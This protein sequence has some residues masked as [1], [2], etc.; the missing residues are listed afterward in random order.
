MT[1]SQLVTMKRSGWRRSSSVIDEI[2]EPMRTNS[3]S[4]TCRLASATPGILSTISASGPIFLSTEICSRKSFMSNFPLSM[5]RASCSAFSSSTTSS[6]CCDEPDH[7]AAAEDPAGHAVGPELF[8]AV[9]R[10]AHT[11]ELD[12]LAGHRFHRQGR[13]AARVAVE[14]GQDDAVVG[15]PVVE[16]L[17]C[18]HRVL[19]DHGVD[20]EERCW[21]GCSAA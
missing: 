18:G 10:L 9:E 3:R 14:L 20:H 17:G 4:S 13:A 7:V 5:R 6:N 16:G 8:Q 21:P 1:S 19:A 2:I 12:R 15:Q 11:H